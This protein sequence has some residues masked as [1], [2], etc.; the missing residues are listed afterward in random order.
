MNLKYANGKIIALATVVLAG[1]SLAAPGAQAGMRI[2]FGFPIG[3]FYAGG[4]H[5]HHHAHRY[6]YRRLQALRRARAI[7]AARRR[8]A[9]AEAAA[10][11]AERKRAAA[12]A[13]AAAKRQAAAELAAA[14][15]KKLE[16]AREAELAAVPLPERKPETPAGEALQTADATTAANSQ[17]ATETPAKLECKRY[18]ANVGMTIRVP[19]SE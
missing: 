19:C 15:Q 6:E 11:R 7:E 4:H 13:A 12:L 16:A 17:P 10:A 9:A 1:L 5:H 2:H 14:E 18:F 3:S 8:Q